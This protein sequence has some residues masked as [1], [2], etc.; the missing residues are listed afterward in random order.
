LTREQFWQHVDPPGDQSLCWL[1]NGPLSA[2]GYGRRGSEF[3]HRVA[4]ELLVGDIPAGLHI[5][6][7]CR[8]RDCVN[9]AHL[10][11]VTP[12]ENQRR[13]VE[14]RLLNR[15]PRTHCPNGHAF[16]ESNTYV[17][18]RP[19]RRPTLFCRACNRVAQQRRAA[20]RRGRAESA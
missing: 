6:H 16:D 1:W 7:L 20:R 17:H 2:D 14:V 19:N 9:P 11:A 3:A 4:Y 13:A 15:G 12:A 10:E 5:D 18:T 8:V